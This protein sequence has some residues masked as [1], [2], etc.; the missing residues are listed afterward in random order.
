MARKCADSPVTFATD[1]PLCKTDHDPQEIGTW[2][3]KFKA[4]FEN[5]GL[6]IIHINIRSLLQKIEQLRIIASL[7]NVDIIS[8]NE[9]DS[10]IKNSEVNIVVMSFTEKTGTR[11]GSGVALYIRSNLPHDVCQNLSTQ[12][13][14][15]VC[16]VTV[17]PKFQ[18]SLLVGSMYRPPNATQE[19]YNIYTCTYFGI[20]SMPQVNH[21][22]Y[23]IE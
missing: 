4:L 17:K 7:G 12:T 15:E 5:K 22:E 11:H 6:K 8:V 10:S 14:T 1:Y 18:N 3:S 9:T 23:A 13:D 16:W 2:G 20:L 21:I 19:Y